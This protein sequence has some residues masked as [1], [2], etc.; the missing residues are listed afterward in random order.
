MASLANAL[1]FGQANEIAN[2]VGDENR[3]V[4]ARSK[5][6]GSNERSSVAALKASGAKKRAM[7]LRL[8][9]IRHLFG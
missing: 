1:F 4:P 7:V 8:K 9:F 2:Q 5:L 3:L 6:N